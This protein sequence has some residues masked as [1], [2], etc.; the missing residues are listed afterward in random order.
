M[1][2]GAI[3]QREVYRRVETWGGPFLA[4]C[5]CPD[6]VHLQEVGSEPS[7]SSPLLPAPAEPVGVGGRL[8]EGGGR[9]QPLGEVVAQQPW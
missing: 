2:N 3:G 8:S 7:T 5:L 6:A 9:S 1:E 4:N